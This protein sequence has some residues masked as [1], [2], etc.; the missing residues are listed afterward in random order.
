MIHTAVM[1]LRHVPITRSSTPPRD[2]YMGLI[3]NLRY[4]RTREVS[5]EHRGLSRDVQRTVQRTF[6]KT[7]PERSARS[8]CYTSPA[9]VFYGLLNPM[10]GHKTRCGLLRQGCKGAGKLDNM[11]QSETHARG[12]QADT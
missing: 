10:P 2:R 9:G 4:R 6:Q 3:R 12:H 5:R 7:V 11:L 1:F 8:V